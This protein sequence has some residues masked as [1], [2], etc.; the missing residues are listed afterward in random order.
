MTF[1]QESFC[2]IEESRESLEEFWTPLKCV[3]AAAAAILG[4]SWNALVPWK[5]KLDSVTSVKKKAA[6]VAPPVAPVVLGV[7]TAV[8]LAIQEWVTAVIKCI[9]DMP[10]DQS[11]SSSSESD[12]SDDGGSGDGK[13]Q[14][15]V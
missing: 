13:E 12:L 9:E 14:K 2:E 1:E 5:S 15:K 3:L 4:E 11:D 8:L 10:S 7:G 6:P